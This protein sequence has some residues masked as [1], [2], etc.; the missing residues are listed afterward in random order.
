MELAKGININNL[1]NEHID[2]IQIPI[3]SAHRNANCI[4]LMFIYE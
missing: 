1:K 3:P 4:L 2:S